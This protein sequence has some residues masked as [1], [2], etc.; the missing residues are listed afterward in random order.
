MKLKLIEIELNTSDPEASKHF[1]IEQLGLK[2]FVDLEGLK[3]FGTGVKGLDLNK[4]KHFPGKVSI[5]FFTKNIQECIDELSAKGVRIEDRYGDPVSA[6]VLQD[7]DGCRVEI[8]K[9]RG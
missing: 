7:P 3:V 8:K 4:S 1:Y 6:I 2:S 9:Q 5:S